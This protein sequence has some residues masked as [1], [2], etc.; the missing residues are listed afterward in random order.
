MTDLEGLTYLV[1]ILEEYNRKMGRE[2]IFSKFIFKYFLQFVK[3]S[4]K[5]IRKRTNKIKLTHT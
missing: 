1:E 3:E 2:E 4:L 5:L